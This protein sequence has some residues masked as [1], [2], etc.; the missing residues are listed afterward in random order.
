MD[1]AVILV[2][3]QGTRMRPLTDTRP[4]PM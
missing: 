4:K 3:G 1:Q 2:G